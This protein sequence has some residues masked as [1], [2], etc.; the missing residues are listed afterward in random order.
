M[1]NI[2]DL[3][4]SNS[5]FIL[6]TQP[7][8][9][10]KLA[11][12]ANK[13]GQDGNIVQFKKVYV[14]DNGNKFK[15]N[16]SLLTALAKGA[17]SD[18]PEQWYLD[19]GLLYDSVSNKIVLHNEAHNNKGAIINILYYNKMDIYNTQ[20]FENEAAGVNRSDMDAYQ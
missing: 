13:R 6:K 18:R 15:I 10:L 7:D 3:P 14:K 9:R 2:I 12:K 20:N 1:S 11:L 19:G 16:P 8:V 17:D 5:K 4:T